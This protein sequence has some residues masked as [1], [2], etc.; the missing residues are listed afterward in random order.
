[1]LLVFAP[2]PYVDASTAWGFRSRLE[3]VAVGFAGVAAELAVAAVAALVWANTAPGTLNALAYNV[4]FVASVSTVVFNLN[5]LLRF[6]GYHML[7]DLI[8]LPNLFQRSRDQL[9][10]LGQRFL[11]GLPSTQPAAR[12][13][14]ELWILP[15]YGVASIVYW[16]L[17]M[18]TIVFFIAEEYLDLGVAL[19]VLLVV[20][21]FVVPAWKF[22]AYLV[23]DPALSVYRGQAVMRSAGLFGLTMLAL[24]VVPVPD[25]VR[26]VGVVQARE[27]QEITSQTEGRLAEML[28][29]PGTLVQEGQPLA[30]L[31]NPQLPYELEGMQMQLQ[32]L[33]AQEIRA[34][35]LAPAEIEALM[36]QQRALLEGLAELERRIEALTV[37]AS[38]SGVWSAPKLA[39]GLGQW[40]PRGQS[41]G[42]ITQPGD[43]RF[44]AVLPQVA[45]HVLGSPIDRA[46]VR[47]RGQEEHN[48]IADAVSV[49]PF[50][51][52]SLPSP[53]LGMA[54]GGLIAVTNDPSGAVAAE[55]F[56]RI[57]GQISEEAARGLGVSMVHGRV[58]TLRLTLKSQPLLLQW[59]RDLRQFFQRRF[60]V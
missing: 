14:S 58:G 31:E 54:G 37:R 52:G 2:M 53:A 45:S 20:I 15:V 47:L 1:M 8:G 13:Q 38:A 24:L 21:T 6:D 55:P 30:R 29:R 16:L 27:A 32:A 4:I 50:E 23:R 33:Q 49:L 43:A 11:L 22:V 3:R 40:V 28:I 60:R 17:L 18:S 44:V 25:R 19:A 59:E 41:L 36:Q 46:E 5:P 26:V 34:V 7:V 9:K 42:T 51:Q 56:F 48:L 57:E 35:A 12:T 39:E 10:Y